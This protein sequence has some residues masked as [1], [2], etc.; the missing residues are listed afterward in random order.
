M[1]QQ[2]HKNTNL[3]IYM[4]PPMFTEALFTRVKIW[5]QPKC[6]PIDDWI[7]KKWHVYTMEYYSA[8]KTNATL[9]FVMT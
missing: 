2:F 4:Q 7:K 3:E 1:I 8:M 9:T 5:K 6:P